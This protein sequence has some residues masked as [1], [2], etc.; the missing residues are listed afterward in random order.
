MFLYLICFEK[1]SGVPENGLLLRQNVFRH[2]WSL[3]FYGKITLMNVCV[4]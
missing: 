4:R 3:V 2:L 1:R